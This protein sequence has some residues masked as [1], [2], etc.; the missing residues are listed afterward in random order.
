MGLDTLVN[1]SLII[2]GFGFLIFVHELG[3]FMAAKW[4]GIRTESFAVGMGPVL[5]SWRKGVGLCAGSTRRALV[6]RFGEDAPEMSDDTLAARGVGESEYSLRALPIGG[7]VRMLGQDD[8]DPSA[9]SDHPRSFN[10]CPIG[11]RMVVVS[12]GVVMNIIAAALLFVY[13]FAVGVRFDAPIIGELLPGSPAATALAVGHD[14]VRLEAGDRV[15]SV[16]GTPVRTFTDVHV[17]A[18]M[19]H[20]DASLHVEVTRGDSRYEFDITPTSISEPGLLELGMVP[21]SSTTLPSGRSDDEIRQYLQGTDLAEQGI[22]PGM[23]MLAA[24]SGDDLQEVE[25]WEAFDAVVQAGQGQ[26]VYTRWRS[27]D[28]TLDATIEPLPVFAVMRIPD[29]P[30]AS[31]QNFER[32]MLGMSPLVRI[33][34]VVEGGPSDGVLHEGDLVLGAGDIQYPRM[35]QLR[36]ALDQRGSGDLAMVVQRDGQRMQIEAKTRGGRLGVVLVDAWETPILAEPLVQTVQV[37]GEDLVAQDTPIAGAQLLGGSTVIAIAGR[38][39]NSWAQMRDAIIDAASRGPDMELEVVNPTSGQETVSIPIAVS[40]SAAAGLADLGWTTPLVSQLFEPLYVTR[41][42]NGNPLQALAMGV[43]ET[44]NMT[45]LTYLTI[46]RLLRRTVGVEQLR[47]PIGIV[48]I[49]SRIA[50]RGISYLFFFLAIIS[51]NLAV[52][53]FLPLPIVDGGLF[54]Y[55]VYEKF[56]GRPPSI[57]FQNAAAVLGLAL[58]GMAFV[59]T[60]YNDI[61]RLVG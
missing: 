61:M 50:D 57:A 30:G 56:R 3:H 21:A 10:S 37:R 52:L 54:L 26:A 31:M 28:G 34:Y 51:V 9:T 11:R 42:S 39:V 17:A 8:A 53:N 55:L 32:G 22:A 36:N 45:V 1:L 38:T 12:A 25:T 13:S 59:V 46:D 5:L 48:H 23:T 35:G 27:G 19:A 43:D 33:V 15:V 18:A 6:D 7:F 49:G 14:D 2:L 29:L 60:F 41:S 4:A 24:G 16:D 47:G 44:W 40:E 20:R 58:I